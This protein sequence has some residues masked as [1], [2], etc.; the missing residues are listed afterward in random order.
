MYFVFPFSPPPPAPCSLAS[1]V[2]ACSA[3][4]VPCGSSGSGRSAIAAYPRPDKDGG[5]RGARLFACH[6]TGNRQGPRAASPRVYITIDVGGKAPRAGGGL[7]SYYNNDIRVLLIEFQPIVFVCVAAL[8]HAHGSQKFAFHVGALP[9]ATPRS[10]RRPSLL[11]NEVNHIK[12]V[13]V[14]M[15]D[16]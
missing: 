14:Y 1:T 6:V 4:S 11:N 15:V 3:A 12:L 5:G 13:N 8:P 7:V 2:Y 9:A 16:S 10:A